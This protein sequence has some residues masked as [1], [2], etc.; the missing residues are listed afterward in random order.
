MMMMMVMVLFLGNGNDLLVIK[1]L[2][3]QVRKQINVNQAVCGHQSCVTDIVG[4][5]S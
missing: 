5:V 4:T 1:S 2:L 3:L